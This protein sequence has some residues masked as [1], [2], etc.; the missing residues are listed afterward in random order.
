MNIGIEE[1]KVAV[2][3]ISV[4]VHIKQTMADLLLDPAGVPHQI[5]TPLFHRKD[6]VTKSPTFETKNCT[7]HR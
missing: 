6:E 1:K 7:Y 2:E 4:L 5:Y 3:A